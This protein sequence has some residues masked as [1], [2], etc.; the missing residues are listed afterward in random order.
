MDT[1]IEV[2]VDVDKNQAVLLP[3]RGPDRDIGL[4]ALQAAGYTIGNHVGIGDNCPVIDPNAKPGPCVS[5]N[6]EA[7][8][9]V[10][11][12]RLGKNCHSSGS[13]KFQ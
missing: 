6:C 4:A 10:N 12:C 7:G 11:Q 8:N 13:W 5:T 3:P 1:N 9:I 2:I